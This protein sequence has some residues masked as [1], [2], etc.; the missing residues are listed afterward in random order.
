M[1][2]GLGGAAR[3]GGAPKTPRYRLIVNV[4]SLTSLTTGLPA[5]SGFFR[6]IRISAVVVTGPVTPHCW[7]PSFGVPVKIFVQLRPPSR[8]SSMSTLLLGSEDDGVPRG[9]TVFPLHS[10]STSRPSFHT[11]RPVF[12]LTTKMV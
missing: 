9:M 5:A 11:S 4:R 2:G 1:R 7:A 12:G 8:E 10:I 3:T 6:V